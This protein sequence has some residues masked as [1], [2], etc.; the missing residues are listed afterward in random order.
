M[1][2]RTCVE[3]FQS[4]FISFFVTST[5]IKTEIKYQRLKKLKKNHSYSLLMHFAPP[6]IHHQREGG[7]GRG[8]RDLWRGTLLPPNFLG[9]PPTDFQVLWGPYNSL[10]FIKEVLHLSSYRVTEYRTTRSWDTI[11]S[12]IFHLLHTSQDHQHTAIRKWSV[13]LPYIEGEH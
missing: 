2:M 9:E 5:V 13:S 8:E 6:W 3:S 12:W 1:R 10:D 4:E 11:H 7:K